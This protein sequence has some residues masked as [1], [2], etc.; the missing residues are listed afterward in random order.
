M[1]LGGYNESHRGDGGIGDCQGFVSLNPIRDVFSQ[2]VTVRLVGGGAGD[3]P[4]RAEG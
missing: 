3:F 2:S 1:W 4:S